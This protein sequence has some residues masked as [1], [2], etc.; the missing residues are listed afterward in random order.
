MLLRRSRPARPARPS[1]SAVLP[2]ARHRA[3]D[4]AAPA[5]LIRSRRGEARRVHLCRTQACDRDLNR[6]RARPGRRHRLLWL[7]LPD[8]PHP[9]HLGVDRAARAGPL[10][11][12]QVRPQRPQYHALRRLLDPEHQGGVSI[13]NGGA[14]DGT[15]TP[16]SPTSSRWSERWPTP[17]TAGRPP[18]STLTP[19]RTGS[20]PVAPPRPPHV[21][22]HRP[23]VRR[24]TRPRHPGS[25][26]A[27]RPGSESRPAATSYAT[28]RRSGLTVWRVLRKCGIPPLENV[29]PPLR[30]PQK[31]RSQLCG[32]HPT[33]GDV[34]YQ[35]PFMVHT[36]PTNGSFGLM[37]LRNGRI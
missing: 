24:S 7:Q 2:Q 10:P 18:A 37:L 32:K 20:P 5:A 33:T 22:P 27:P 31:P 29:E 36:N 14:G 19:Q 6:R 21:Q 4:R 9:H 35:W 26:G 23:G 15:Q 1:I 13:R 25:P 11:S 16:D 8:E 30:N 3:L 17:R 12:V 28:E 34:S